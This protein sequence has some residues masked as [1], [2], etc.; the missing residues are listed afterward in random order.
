M[1][2]EN[3]TV[4]GI[5]ERTDHTTEKGIWDIFR[6]FLDKVSLAIMDVL[7]ISSLY[8]LMRTRREFQ[9]LGYNGS[10]SHTLKSDLIIFSV[11]FTMNNPWRN[12]YSDIFTFMRLQDCNHDA[13]HGVRKYGE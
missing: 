3:E 7:S 2:S 1:E 8:C 4:P 13:I 5:V 6:T 10:L 12:D 9:R 11:T